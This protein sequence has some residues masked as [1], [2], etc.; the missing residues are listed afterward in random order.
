MGGRVC[1]RVCG[2]VC[3]R[4]AY[5]L[6]CVTS[7]ATKTFKGKVATGH[8]AGGAEEAEDAKGVEG[9]AEA[10]ENSDSF[11]WATGQCQSAVWTLHIYTI[12][13]TSALPS[14]PSSPRA[15]PLTP[16]AFPSTPSRLPFP[17]SYHR[18]IHRQSDL[19]T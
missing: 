1:G 16:P 19:Q 14:P 5:L 9:A 6:S 10:G 2:W 11:R 12:P 4:V 7:R 3:G 15:H 18:S 17:A 8:E 13:M